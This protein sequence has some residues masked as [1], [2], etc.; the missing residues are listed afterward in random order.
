MDNSND[1]P[2]ALISAIL[3]RRIICSCLTIII[4]Y[5]SY[6]SLVILV[7]ACFNISMF[8]NISMLF[9]NFVYTLQNVFWLYVLHFKDTRVSWVYTLFSCTLALMKKQTIHHVPMTLN[10]DTAL[11]LITL[12]VCVHYQPVV[13]VEILVT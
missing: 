13:L 9:I 10:L 3:F 6:A 1:P 8:F 7:V 12:G 5:F 4:I 2:A 11:Q